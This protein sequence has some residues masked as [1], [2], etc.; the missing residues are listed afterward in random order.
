MTALTLAVNKDG[1]LQDLR[2]GV[3]PK[4]PGPGND[5]QQ[6]IFD[7]A[8]TPQFDGAVKDVDK[9]KYEEESED[10]ENLYNYGYGSFGGTSSKR[11]EELNEA[12][13]KV[14]RIVRGKRE[15]K[16]VSRLKKSREIAAEK[17][18]RMKIEKERRQKEEEA[19][20]KVQ[21]I[22]RGRMS[23]QSMKGEISIREKAATAIQSMWRGAKHRGL[24][25]LCFGCRF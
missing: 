12:A 8:A 19:A 22:I 4:V 6:F 7:R 24:A 23:R 14:Q 9:D 13:T 5:V 15:R 2:I 17:E 10:E 3:R 16:R 1:T 25:G 11:Y 20:I 18:K 21:S